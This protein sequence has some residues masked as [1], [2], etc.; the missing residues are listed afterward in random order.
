[1]I[2]KTKPKKILIVGAG[3][4][5]ICV[6][7]RLHENQFSFKIVDQGFNESSQVAAGVINPLVFR[8]TTKSWRV[9]EFL[10][11]AVDFYTNLG[12]SWG[13]NYYEPIPIRRAFSHQQE[14][15]TWLERQNW[16]DYDPFMKTI[17]GE[18]ENFA[19]VKNTF[20]TGV[21]LQAAH[22]RT[23]EFLK[24]A[25]TWLLDNN[26]LL[27][28]TFRY[29]ELDPEEGTFEG[30]KYDFII[31]CE[32]YRGI[33][34]PFFNYLPLE[35]TKG[36]ILTI[37]SEEIANEE[38]LNRKCF[39]L[40]IGK[41]QFKVGATYSWRSANTDLTSAA[42]DLL[43]D[44]ANTL[45]DAKMKIIDHQAGVRPTVLDRRPLIGTH[46]VYS[47]LKIFNGLGAKGYMMA[48]LLSQEFVT[49][50]TKN[51]ILDKEVDIERYKKRFNKA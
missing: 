14:K 13:N 41:N 24:D 42:R 5:G 49:Y 4:A 31:F 28:K 22:I 9:D 50:L 3:L 16:E 10:P 37:E 45:V 32:G 11:V 51:S 35:A 2:E 39:I 19:G 12:K 44:Q 38:L 43:F 29:E 46:P 20:G 25:K 26:L 17:D 21:V 34:N 7:R 36:E 6:A 40:P 23:I 8:R 48:P 1:M 15:E 33:D 30:E 18:D 27:E 47:K